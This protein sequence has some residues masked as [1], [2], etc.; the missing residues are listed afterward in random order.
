MFPRRGDIY[1]CP[2]CLLRFVV[3][4]GCHF[5]ELQTESMR[6]CC[7]GIPV[8]MQS[9]SESA[10]ESHINKIIEAELRQRHEEHV[11]RW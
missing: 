11:S 4:N 9:G 3:V 10:T 1:E 7:G 6:C 5:S 8:L 2:Q